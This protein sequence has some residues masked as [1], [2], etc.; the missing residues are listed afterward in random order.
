[1]TVQKPC[2]YGPMLFSPDD[3][4]IGRSLDLYGEFSDL[5]VQGLLKL[6]NQNSVVLDIGANI[7]CL[8]VPLAQRSRFVIAAEPQRVVFQH[9]CANI[10]LAGLRNVDAVRVA[11]GKEP[12][13]VRIAPLDFDAAQN[14]GGYSLIKR[15]VGEPTRVV[16]IDGLGLNA[17]HLIKIDVE[18]MEPDVLFGGRDTIRKYKPAIYVEADRDDN[19]PKI[20]DQIFE[21]GYR[22][23]WHCPPLF[24]PQNT[25]GN[26]ENVFPNTVSINLLCLP[27]GVPEGLEPF[28]AQAGDT[29]PGLKKRLYG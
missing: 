9:L 6:V 22:A 17:C 11:F 14:L 3:M 2:K 10:A 25:N 23:W 19:A 13:V 18:G 5:E 29:F 21:F 24:N 15:D 1:M 20:I 12:D 28:E 16:T 4:F 26:S 27:E 8:T 7:G